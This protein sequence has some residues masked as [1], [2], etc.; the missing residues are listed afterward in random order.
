MIDN[1]G[2]KL[3]VETNQGAPERPGRAHRPD[4]ARR[5]E[6]ADRPRRAPGAAARTR[7]SAGGKLFATYL[8]DVTT[9]AYVHRLDGTLE[10]EVTLP[11]LGTAGGFGGERDDT[12]VFYTF[13]S[14]DVPPTIYRYDM[15]TTQEHALPRAQRSRVRS[16]RRYETKQVFY[17]SKDGTRIPMF[18]DAPEGSEARRHAIRR[19][20]TAT[21]GSTSPQAPTFSVAATGAARAGRSSTRRRTCAAAASTARRGTRPA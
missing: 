20:S 8:K 10:N 7:R 19:C 18:L 21:A 11:G 14:F 5:I 9:R 17:P 4:A 6:L 3:L 12:F 13:T 2:D 1:V 16:G 15:A